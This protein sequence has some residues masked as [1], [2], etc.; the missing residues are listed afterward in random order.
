M[1]PAPPTNPPA[2][3]PPTQRATCAREMQRACEG[4]NALGNL[5]Y[6]VC[7]GAH[8]CRGAPWD[9]SG[10]DEY[11]HLLT[12]GARWR[13]PDACAAHHQP[14]ADRRGCDEVEACM[15]EAAECNRASDMSK[16]AMAVCKEMARACDALL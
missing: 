14:G 6:T 5:A 15:V 16:A 13:L 12:E 7:D 10:R 3:P 2:A 1:P 4:A 11:G 9:S 8:R